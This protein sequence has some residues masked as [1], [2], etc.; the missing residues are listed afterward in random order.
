MSRYST[1]VQCSAHSICSYYSIRGY[2]SIREYY[3]IRV[4]YDIGG[5]ITVRLYSAM[6]LVLVDIILSTAITLKAFLTT[7]NELFHT[8]HNA[9]ILLDSK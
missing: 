4:Y 1:F 6:H 8:Q 3:S 9:P 5:S 2:Y 7:C